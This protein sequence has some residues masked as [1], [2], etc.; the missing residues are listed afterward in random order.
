LIACRI[1][2]MRQGK[3]LFEGTIDAVLSRYATLEEAFIAITGQ[4]AP[5]TGP[6]S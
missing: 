5:I 2:I 4:P 3:L 1:G 6:I